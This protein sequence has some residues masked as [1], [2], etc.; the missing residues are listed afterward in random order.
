MA[1]VAGSGWYILGPQVKAFETAFAAYLD[2]E[3]CI[4]VANGT[5]ALQIALRACNVGPGKRVITVANAG[6]Y[7]TTAILNVGAEPV[8]VDIDPH[9]LL[10][11]ID[12]LGSSIMSGAAALVAT[13]LYGRMLDMPALMEIANR[14]EVPVIEDV[15]QA[16]GARLNGKSAGSWGRLGCFSFYPTKNLGALGDGG[17]VVTNDTAAAERVRELRQYGWQHKY[18]TSIAGGCNSRLDELQAAILLQKLPL[19]DGWNQ[20]RQAIARAYVDAFH[21]A[22]GTIQAT[23]TDGAH[24]VA[25]LFVVRSEHRDY[26]RQHLT[27]SGIGTDVHYPVPDHRQPAWI[28]SSWA[29]CKLPNTEMACCEVLTLPCFPE[30]ADDEVL[31]VASALSEVT[32]IRE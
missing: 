8:Y 4:G 17:A 24:Y 31:S 6:G 27:A 16:H 28:K 7:S 3:Y 21:S 25:H 23:H 18:Q 22:T 15:A 29:Q 26:L 2:M 13:H 32:A 9:T 1:R 11:D 14:H 5:D 12:S 20:R 19:L 10:L 30:L